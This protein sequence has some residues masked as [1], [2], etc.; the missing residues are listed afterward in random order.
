[1]FL[2]FL[3][4]APFLTESVRTFII[5]HWSVSRQVTTRHL[6]ASN[7]DNLISLDGKENQILPEDAFSWLVEHMSCQSDTVIDIDS[8]KASTFIA[9]LK[10]GR[11]AVWITSQ[12][13]DVQLRLET[14]FAQNPDSESE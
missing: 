4:S 3:V 8:D 6:R 13:C 2:I 9:A 11:N 7:L 14:V 5:A 10:E 12:S 1:M